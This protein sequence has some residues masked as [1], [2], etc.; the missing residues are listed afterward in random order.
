MAQRS[1]EVLK[2]RRAERMRLGKAVCEIVEFLSD[3]EI[4]LA[5]VP[6]T[7]AEFQNSLVQAAQ[8]NVTEISSTHEVILR[9]RVQKCAII[10]SAA[11]ETD[12]LT[13][14]FFESMLE[15]TSLDA[16]DINHVFSYYEQMMEF[17]SPSLE[18]LSQADMDEIKKALEEVD[19]NGLSG[20]SW[21]AAKRF[22]L[23]LSPQQPPDNLFGSSQTQSLTTKTDEPEFIPIA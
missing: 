22:L 7:D 3:P 13:K 10:L 18:D 17:S 1:Y 20:R 15:V 9:D 12:D 6:L 8:A 5:L 4:R 23:T 19:W 11:R 21:Y 2:E 16:N 14:P